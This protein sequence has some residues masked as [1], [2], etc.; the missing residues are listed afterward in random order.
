MRQV[1]QPVPVSIV[2][3]LGEG[4]TQALLLTIWSLLHGT[5]TLFYILFLE[6]Q[7]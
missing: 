3:C 4:Q 7:V 2:T 1:K 5:H 6:G